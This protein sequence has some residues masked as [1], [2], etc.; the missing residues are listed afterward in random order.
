MGLPDFNG[1]DSVAARREGRILAKGFGP[2]RRLLARAD[3]WRVL[4]CKSS[5]LLKYERSFQLLAVREIEAGSFDLRCVQRVQLLLVL[6]AVGEDA[7]G[8]LQQVLD[9][10]PSRLGQLSELALHFAL[11]QAHVGAQGAH[12]QAHVL[13]L[14][15]WPADWQTGK[16]GGD[17]RR[18]TP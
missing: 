17:A 14:R 10:G 11:H 16:H 15:D 9:L 1:D 8:M 12:G 18:R 4:R 7:A 13:E 2:P 6:G 3:D 5:S